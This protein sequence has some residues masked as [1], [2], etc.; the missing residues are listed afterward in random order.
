MPPPLPVAL[1]SIG[2]EG[3]AATLGPLDSSATRASPVPVGSGEVG[4][5][6]SAIAGTNHPATTRGVHST[7]RLRLFAAL[8]QAER[9]QAESGHGGRFRD[10]L[11]AEVARQVPDV[12]AAVDV[13]RIL[14]GGAVAGADEG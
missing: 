3:V 5:H 11:D 7:E 9:A 12:R 10:R 14:A 6:G 8:E 13:D 1:L 4:R 2:D